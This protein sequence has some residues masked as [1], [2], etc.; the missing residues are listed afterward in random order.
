MIKAERIYSF[1][2]LTV[3]LFFWHE[4][5]SITRELNMKKVLL[6]KFLFAEKI[7]PLIGISVVVFF[8]LHV[9]QLQ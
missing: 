4:V 1:R 9:N 7:V 5:R 6:Q 3:K 2:I 8:F